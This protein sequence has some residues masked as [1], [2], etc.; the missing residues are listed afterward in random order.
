MKSLGA[1]MARFRPIYLLLFP[2]YIALLWVPFY[3]RVEPTL[4]ASRSST[5]IRCSGFRWAR[6]FSIPIYRAEERRKD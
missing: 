5:G 3:N 4:S 2:P 1:S 6:C